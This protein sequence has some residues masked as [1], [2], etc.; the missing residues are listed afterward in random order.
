MAPRPSIAALGGGT[1]LSSLL[2]GLKLAPVDLTAI[3]TVADDGGS[4]GR[5]RR[6]LGI[7]PPGDIRNC[8]VALADDESLM[9][10]LFQ[11]RFADGDLSGHPFGNLF[12]AALTEVTGD[13]D[14]AIQEC[15]RVLKIRGAVMPSTLHQVRLWAERVDGTVVCGETNIAAG[16]AACRRVW[17]DPVPEAYPPAV[18]ALARADVIVLG[19]GSLF[20]SVLAHL[21]VPEI[22]AAVSDSRGL[23]VYVCNVMTQP[24]ETD[25]FCAG[26][27]VTRVLEAVPGGVDVVVL[28]EGEF[29]PAAIEAYAA[30]G[31]V[32]VEIDR[33]RLDALGVRVV[34]APLAD[35]GGV[36]RHSPQALADVILGL[37]QD[38]DALR[39]ASPVGEAPA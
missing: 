11:H 5:L 1:G 15:S 29:D 30:M 19:P 17:F 6:E 36:V 13:F 4:S 39:S 38:R 18:A 7:L 23:R 8:L 37:T 9:G 28:H 21:A 16:F 32:P 14:L 25:G 3:V 31:Q 34:T 22:A 12:L 26:D 2:R 27:H 20:T 10:R 35:A 24:G 33:A